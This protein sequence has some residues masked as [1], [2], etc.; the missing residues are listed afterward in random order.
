MPAP[1]VYF[2]IA[3]PSVQ[4]Q[5]DFYEH[6]F[7]WS[8]DV[9]GVV[10]VPVDGP[11]LRGTLRS[12]PAAKVIYLGVIDIIATQKAIVAHGGRVIAP[13]FEVKG[14]AVLALFADPA[15]NDMGL[16][17]LTPDGKTKVP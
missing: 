15:G 7:G 11:L 13:R 4:Q 1:I 10:S 12:D 5:S 6:V 8:V 17:E 9:G 3:G 14:V 16:V 2:D